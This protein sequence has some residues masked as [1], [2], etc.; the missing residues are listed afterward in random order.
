MFVTEESLDRTSA[1]GHRHQT[2][3]RFL[4]GKQFPN[5]TME[6]LS[7]SVTN[8]N[9]RCVPIVSVKSSNTLKI[10]FFNMVQQH[11]HI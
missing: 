3:S 10:K 7:Y 8:S 11:F 5:H 1:L 9:H 2:S 6:R 4:T